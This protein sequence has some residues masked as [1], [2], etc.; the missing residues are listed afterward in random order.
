[1][2]REELKKRLEELLL[3]RQD[4]M[5][6]VIKGE[7]GIGKTYLWKEFIEA[8]NTNF[9]HIYIS[10][11][12]KN[13]ISDIKIDFVVQFF[14]KTSIFKKI[15]GFFKNLDMPIPKFKF[16]TQLVLEN[17]FSI[18]PHK[19]TRK[20]IACFDEFERMSK[21]INLLEILGFMS[22]LKDN[23]GCKVVAILNEDFLKE[24]Q[25][26]SNVYARFKEKIID[27][28]V[29]LAPSTDENLSVV[30]NKLNPPDS[31]K[32]SMKKFIAITGNQLKNIRII[33]R[34]IRDAMHDFSFVNDLKIENEIKE[35]LYLQ[36]FSFLYPYIKYQISPENFIQT[37]TNIL[38]KK[39][40]SFVQNQEALEDPIINQIAYQ[41]YSDNLGNIDFSMLQ[42]M[43][44][45]TTSGGLNEPQK[46]EIKK[47]LENKNSAYNISKK[48]ENLIN[49]LIYNFNK[50]ANEI[51]NEAKEFFN[52]EEIKS[53][54]I[55]YEMFF[56]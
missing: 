16:Q 23:L 14:T 17:L 21:N 56:I 42:L 50:P 32:N 48:I 39:E 46:E 8:K 37:I 28:E 5:C 29:T 47:Y 15:L 11:F 53:L 24:N 6:I 27:F 4:P 36:F 35:N 1:M 51:Y 10:L 12:G 38:N 25:D 20:I 52:S 33:E 43:E 41:I 31:I 40:K 7:W 2:T 49:E 22:Y 13:S 55:Q 34:M 26:Y 9:K 18:I 19:Q 45:Y 30:F 3:Q 44:T 54:F